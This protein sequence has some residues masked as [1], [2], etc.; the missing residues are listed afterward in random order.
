[1]S[2]D[3]GKYDSSRMKGYAVGNRHTMP[4]SSGIQITAIRPFWVGSD[5]HFRQSVLMVKPQSVPHLN[6]VIDLTPHIERH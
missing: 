1:M 3:S 2:L 6:G 5:D 4:A